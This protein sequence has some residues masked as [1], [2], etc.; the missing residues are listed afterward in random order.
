MLR[1]AAAMIDPPPERI[2]WCYG[3]WQE[4][5]AT[6]ELVDVRFD[7]GLPS[8]KHVRFVNDDPHRHGR[9]HGRNGRTG[10]DLVH[11]KKSSLEHVHAVSRT[12][13][14]P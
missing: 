2:M 14:V 3:E 7:E 4:A 8:A 13:P 11:L 5:Y 1:H 9:S 10:H 12:E 6:M